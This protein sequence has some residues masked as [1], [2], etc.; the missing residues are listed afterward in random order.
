MG[1]DTPSSTSPK[2]L[3]TSSAPS[4]GDCAGVAAW[5][6]SIVYEGGQKATYHAHLW[7]AKWWTQGDVPGGSAEAWADDGPC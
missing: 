3:P 6:S 2:P 5:G 4:S 1:Q 7:I